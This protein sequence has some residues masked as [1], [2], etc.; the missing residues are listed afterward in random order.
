MEFQFARAMR[1][2]RSVFRSIIHSDIVR[3]EIASYAEIMRVVTYWMFSESIMDRVAS[4][5]RPNIVKTVTSSMVFVLLYLV[6]E[7]TPI[8]AVLSKEERA[9]RKNA[10]QQLK[11]AREVDVE[12]ARCR[13]AQQESHEKK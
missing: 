10:Q 12:K 8:G 7:A 5:S 2:L 13:A 3:Q 6:I 4:S 1:R 11:R 9:R